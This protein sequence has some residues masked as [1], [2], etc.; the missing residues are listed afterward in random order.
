MHL[1]K[2]T[3]VPQL[4]SDLITH[5]EKVL[6]AKPPVFNE[7]LPSI[8]IADVN[9]GLTNATQIDLMRQRGAVARRLDVAHQ[10]LTKL[11][12]LESRLSAKEFDKRVEKMLKRMRK[13]DAELTKF[14]DTLDA[15]ESENTGTS[16]KAITAFITFEEEEGY[17]RCVREY[18]DRGVLQRLFQSRHK[19]FRGKRLHLKVAP[20]PTDILWENLDYSWL[21]RACRTIVVNCVTVGLLLVSFVLIYLTKQ[22]KLNLERTFGR[23]TSCPDPG[24]LTKQDVIVDQ[25]WEL[26]HKTT[27]DV[28]VECYC[29]EVLMTNSF[30]DMLDEVFVLDDGSEELY[31]KDWATAFAY[32]QVG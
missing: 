8:K 15:W 31:C 13:I 2:H 23:A 27:Y 30:S 3:N 16:L 22:E 7:K 9:F 26:Y 17:L 14:D 19:R 4:E 12:L 20:N 18:P 32:V 24:L 10:Q 28:L 29:K 11:K 6:S 21:S 25:N 1:P 5:L